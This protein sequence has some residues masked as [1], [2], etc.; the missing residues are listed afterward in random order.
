[1]TSFSLLAVLRL[2]GRQGV[3]AVPATPGFFLIVVR[4]VQQRLPLP[5]MD[6]ARVCS[7][8]G[9]SMQKVVG[10]RL[11]ASYGV[12]TQGSRATTTCPLPA[13]GHVSGECSDTGRFQFLQVG[14]DL[15]A[16]VSTWKKIDSRPSGFAARLSSRFVG[17]WTALPCAPATRASSVVPRLVA[18]TL[19]PSPYP[20]KFRSWIPRCRAFES[21]CASAEVRPAERGGVA[22]KSCSVERS[23][24]VA[25]GNPSNKAS[26]P[27]KVARQ[28]RC[29]C[30]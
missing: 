12:A 1:M 20:S 27:L 24:L 26:L 28:M 30:R 29:L 4:V 11:G 13:L 10:E 25:V 19:P 8:R 23:A 3:P 6:S 14:R 22:A 21:N 18:L 7:W 17:C 16:C 15:T 2:F 9:A 5:I